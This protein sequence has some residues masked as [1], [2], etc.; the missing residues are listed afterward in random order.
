MNLSH[1]CKSSFKIPFYFLSNNKSEFLQN[2]SHF[3]FFLH[4]KNRSNFFNK[5]FFFL[6]PQTIDLI[7]TN[8]TSSFLTFQSRSEF[9]KSNLLFF[10]T[11]QTTN[12][13]FFKKK[14]KNLFSYPL[15]TIGLIF[16]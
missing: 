1:E 13:I 11:S 8:Q 12:L 6:T 15:Q 2:K 9:Y 5:I 4:Y 3:F 14:K 7:F 10:L 16:L